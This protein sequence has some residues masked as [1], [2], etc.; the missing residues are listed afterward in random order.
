MTKRGGKTGASNNEKPLKLD[1]KTRRKTNLV[2][3]VY[4]R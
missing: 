2:E 1:E 4:K 3:I